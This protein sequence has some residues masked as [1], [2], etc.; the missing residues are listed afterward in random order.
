MRMAIGE[1]HSDFDPLPAFGSDGLR[2]GFQLLGHQA[3]EQRDILE[4][5]AIV[6]LEEVAHDDAA[7]RLV[8]VDADEVDWARE[9]FEGT[10]LVYLA[11]KAG[12]FL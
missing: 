2:L 4:P 12:F 6:V 7:G 3:L 8:G 9:G 5:A 11:M 10:K 1:L